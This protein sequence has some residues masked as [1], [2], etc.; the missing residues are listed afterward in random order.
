MM[1]K[2]ILYDTGQHCR[3]NDKGEAHCVCL[4]SCSKYNDPR[5]A[6]CSSRN[7][8]YDSECEFYRQVRQWQTRVD[9]GSHMVSGDQQLYR[10]ETF[11]RRCASAKGMNVVAPIDEW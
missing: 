11:I 2:E 4:E 6:I 5:S 3:L 8:T 7:I 10:N 1:N 9:C